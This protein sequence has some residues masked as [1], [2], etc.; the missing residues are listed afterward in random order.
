MDLKKQKIADLKKEQQSDEIKV[1][2]LNMIKQ[3]LF[4]YRRYHPSYKGTFSELAFQLYTDFLAP[5]KHRNGEVYSELDRFEPGEMGGEDWKGEVGET[6]KKKL[7]AYVQ[8]FVVHR[9][10]DLE[11]KDK[12]EATYDENFDVAGTVPLDLIASDVPDEDD[13]WAVLS[14]LISKGQ[15]LNDIVFTE[16]Q[17]N[18]AK[19]V[20]NNMSLEQKI[21]FLKTYEQVKNKPQTPQNL[22]DFFAEVVGNDTYRGMARQRSTPKQIKQASSDIDGIREDLITSTGAERVDAYKLQGKDA[23][24]ILFSEPATHEGYESVDEALK[25]LGYDFYTAR[26]KAWYYIKGIN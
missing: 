18:K 9:L 10:I 26:P 14:G 4:K 20:Y 11:R 24:R 2:V 1:E 22:K 12:G 19:E 8:R 23:V 13:N 17:K 25:E 6:L 21:E 7:A 15:G 3:F 16:E 5:K